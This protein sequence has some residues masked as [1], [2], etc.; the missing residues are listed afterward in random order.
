MLVRKILALVFFFSFFYRKPINSS[1]SAVIFPVLLPMTCL[2]HDKS[3]NTVS[4]W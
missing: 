2:K 4:A 3:R 1:M